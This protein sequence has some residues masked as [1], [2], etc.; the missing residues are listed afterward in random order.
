MSAMNDSAVIAGLIARMEA[1]PGFAGLGSSVQTISELGEDVDAGA[2]TIAAAILRD[3]ALTARLL[4]LANSSARGGTKNVTTIDQALV[5][6][7]LKTVKSVALSLALLNSL[8]SKPQSAQLHAEIAASYFCGSLAAEI[9]RL[10]A[11]RFSQQEAQV[12]GLLQNLGRMMVLYY[13]YDTVEQIRALQ[14]RENL[15]EE[16]AVQRTQGASYAE[17]AHSIAHHWNL[18]YIIQESL[19]PLGSKTPPRAIPANAAA[20][21]QVC[22]TFTRRITDA[23]FR[24]PENREKSE[25]SGAIEFFKLALRLNENE[26]RESIDRALEEVGTLLGEVGFPCSLDQARATLRKA[27]ERTVDIL[28]GQDSLAKQ[29]QPNAQAPIEIINHALRL[30]HDRY[31]FDR[32]LLCLPEGKTGL[33]AI[34]GV[35]RSVGALI[36]KFRCNGPRPDIFRVVLTKQSDVYIAYTKTPAYEKLFPFWYTE[37]VGATACLLL[38]LVRDNEPLGLIYGDYAEAPD[39]P[40][41][42]YAGGDVIGWRDAIVR[43][44]LS[45]KRRD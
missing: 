20:W 12:C 9:T 38:P 31:R 10:Y 27:S 28:S 36:P 42:D 21:H 6:L 35:G 2:R 40:P 1:D 11:P 23:F 45:T 32:T 19:A 25:L 43:A 39:A 4:K 15:E 5:I 14:V 13:D 24:L 18:P 3:A 41:K 7:G 17:I 26:T 16:E 8:S 29:R 30:I 33:M 34:A 44:L 37:Q 22:T